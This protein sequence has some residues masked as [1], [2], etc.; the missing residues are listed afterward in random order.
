MKICSTLLR[1]SLLEISKDRENGVMFVVAS[2]EKQCSYFLNYSEVAIEIYHDRR[3]EREKVRL[4]E[5]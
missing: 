2:S 1:E 5:A 3:S 4:D